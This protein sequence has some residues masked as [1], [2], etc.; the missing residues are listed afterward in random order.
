VSFDRDKVLSALRSHRAHIERDYGMRLV[1]IVGSM[2][3]GEATAESDIDVLV[4]ILETPTLF[5]I[6]E[7]EQELEQVVGLGLPVEFVFRED[8]KPAMRARM[9]R[10]FIPLEG[11][12][13][14]A[15]R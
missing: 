3:R 13:G 15:A 10:D 1:G 11:A 4:D 14:N 12:S 5:Q 9:E 2:A 7:A 6:A 8:L